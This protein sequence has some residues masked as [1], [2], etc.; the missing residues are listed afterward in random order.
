MQAVVIEQY[1]P[2]SVLQARDVPLPAIKSDEVLLEVAATSINPF[3]LKLRSGAV[4][5]FVPLTFPAILGLDVSGTVTSVGADVRDLAPGDKVFGH[6][7]QTYA[8]LCAVKGT[9]LARL[10]ERLDLVE[11]AALPTVLTTG[12]QLGALA[13]DGQNRRVLVTGAVGNVG[14]SAVAF[15]KAK[16]VFVVAGVLRRQEK[17]VEATGADEVLFLDDASALAGLAA[18]D[19]LADTIGGE[20]VDRLVTRIRPQG[21][22]ATVLQVPASVA[23]RSDLRAHSMQMQVDSALLLFMTDALLRGELTIPLGDR[24]ALAQASAA[25]TAAEAGSAGKLLLIP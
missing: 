25:H 13:L 12:A 20:T 6:A 19:G 16:G 11:A 21:T 10:P 5:E 18:L 1:G 24:F 3:D 4:R 8:S 7:E 17:L 14:R 23:S 22:F 2:P 15:L 9:A